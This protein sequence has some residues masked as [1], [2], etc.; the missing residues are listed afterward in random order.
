MHEVAS[1]HQW[2]DQFA[3]YIRNPGDGLPAIMKDERLA[4]YRELFFN[5]VESIIRRAFPVAIRIIGEELWSELA[6]DY[7]AR[8]HASI[9]SYPRLASEFLEYL[10]SCELDQ[11][12]PVFLRELMHYEWL[13]LELDLAEGSMTEGEDS[14]VLDIVPGLSPVVRLQ[15]YSFPVHRISPDFITDTRDQDTHLLLYR[16][17]D[18]NVRFNELAPLSMALLSLVEGNESESGSDLVVALMEAIPAPVETIR[19]HASG[20]LQEMYEKGIVM[21]TSLEKGGTT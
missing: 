19:G 9:R 1:L 11:R 2:Q 7:F 14:S 3:G 4:V 16:D 10:S 18:W 5:N 21:P 15:T 13:E 20:F 8:H 6:V 12:Y 17:S